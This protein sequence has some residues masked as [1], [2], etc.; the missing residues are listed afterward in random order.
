M[1]QKAWDRIVTSWGP[2]CPGPHNPC[3]IPATVVHRKPKGHPIA[4][5]H[6]TLTLRSRFY[7]ATALLGRCWDLGLRL[8]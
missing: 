6:R 8:E 1:E 5:C 2:G 3:N 4:E 7:G